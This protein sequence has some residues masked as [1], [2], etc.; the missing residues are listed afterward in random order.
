MERRTLL[1]SA[2][3][4]SAVLAAPRMLF[5]KDTTELTVYTS[6]EADQL[7]PFK[8]LFESDVPDVKIN[9]VRD[10][11]G[12]MTT[13]LL[14]EESNPQADVI[15]AIAASAVALFESR[16]MLH[17]YT[18]VGAENLRTTPQFRSPSEPT[19]WTG[20]SAFISVMAANTLELEK[21]G[22]AV[23]QHWEDLLNPGLKG[24]VVMPNPASSATGYYTIS[25]WMKIM[26]E[27][28][29]WEF[30]DAL[31]AN[32]GVYTHSGSQPVVRAARGEY[33]IGVGSDLRAAREKTQGAPIEI[34]VPSEGTGWDMD[35]MAIV[36]GTQ[37]LEAAKKLVDWAHTKKAHE[38]YGTTYA[39]VGHKEVNTAPPNYPKNPGDLMA[40]LKFSWM[41]ENRE[42]ILAEWAR[43]YDGKSAPRG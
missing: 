43:R 18:P 26:G 21:R 4:G 37:K 24:G 42:R 22:V 16:G 8:T 2:L 33:T 32:I 36:K 5:A 39:I 15:I 10:S 19:A 1:K 35:G 12:I 27:E 7:Q 11:S 20:L 30:M 9:F 38:F 3:A 41:A 17:G 6:F 31:H 23:P 28:K 29:A 25:G 14:A 34:V 40:D 13:R